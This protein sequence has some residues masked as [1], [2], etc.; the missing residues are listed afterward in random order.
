MSYR[1]HQ[2]FEN[3]YRRR[4]IYFVVSDK[5]PQNPPK[6]F[7]ELKQRCDAIKTQIP[8]QGKNTGFVE[9][10][11]MFFKDCGLIT[12]SNVA[13]LSNKELCDDIFQCTMNPLG[14]VLQ[15]EGLPMVSSRTNRYYCTKNRG[16]A[17]ECDGEIYFITSQWYGPEDSNPTKVEFYNRVVQMALK[18]LPP[19]IA[20][21][22]RTR[23]LYW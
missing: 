18:N 3:F 17:V 4:Q 11:F 5:D 9:L 21:D 7:D 15:R 2:N 13:F 6:T 12:R 16:R 23:E 14:G 10:I 1:Y 20:D 8:S 19:H 22:P